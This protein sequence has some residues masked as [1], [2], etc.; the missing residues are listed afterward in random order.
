VLAGALGASTIL[1]RR[2]T[3]YPL[4]K[5]VAANLLYRFST[6]EKTYALLLLLGVALWLLLRPAPIAE[7]DAADDASAAP[8]AIPV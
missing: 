1:G 6:S 7:T 4:P 8:V 2:W 5:Q 3:S